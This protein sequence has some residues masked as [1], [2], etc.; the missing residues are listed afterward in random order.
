MLLENKKKEI[1][2]NSHIWSKIK[3]F[4]MK[5]LKIPESTNE[6]IMKKKGTE[7]P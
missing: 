1:W 7:F 3:H 5:I 2:Q 6:I 4:M